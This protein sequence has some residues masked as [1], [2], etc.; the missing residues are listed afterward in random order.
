MS[1]DVFV[2]H[3]SEDKP[4]VVRPLSQALA[5]TGIS[6]WVDEAEIHCGDSIVDKVSDGRAHPNM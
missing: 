4:D 1:R 5:A 2:C 3:A 6:S